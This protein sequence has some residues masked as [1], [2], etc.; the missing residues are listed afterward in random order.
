MTFKNGR[1]SYNAASQNID[2][3]DVEKLNDDDDDDADDA[4]S[5]QAL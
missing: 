5:R 1:I 2:A 4:F 3:K